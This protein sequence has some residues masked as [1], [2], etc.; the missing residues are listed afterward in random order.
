MAGPGDVQRARHLRLTRHR[1]RRFALHL[2]E[3]HDRRHEVAIY[4]T[5]PAVVPKVT[6]PLSDASSATTTLPAD[7]VLEQARRTAL[8][9]GPTPEHCPRSEEHTYQLQP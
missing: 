9:A 6:P 1:Q 2:R 5:Q 8:F 4:V 3:R 7:I